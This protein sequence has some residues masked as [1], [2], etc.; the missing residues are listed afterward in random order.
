MSDTK[1]ALTRCQILPSK[2]TKSDFGSAPPQTPSLDLGALLLRERGGE[3]RKRE[4][5]GGKKREKER[6]RWA[7]RRRSQRK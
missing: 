2:C 1:T 3:G 4:E 7:R 6:R 5:K